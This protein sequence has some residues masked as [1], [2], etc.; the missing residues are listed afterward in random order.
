MKRETNVLIPD[1]EKAPALDVIRCLSSN[2]NINIHVLS[3]EK[4]VASRFSRHISSFTIIP[5][6]LE[7]QDLIEI[8][9]QN[10]RNKKI[11]VLLPVFI[12]KIKFISRYKESFQPL[13]NFVVP[14]LEDFITANNKWKLNNFLEE[15]NI[16]KPI[17]YD[18]DRLNEVKDN[19][20]FPVLLKPVY[21]VGGEGIIKVENIKELIA[22]SKYIDPND[23]Y[24]IQNYIHGYDIDMSVLCENGKILAFTIQKGILKRNVDSF[25]APIG[26]QF[27]YEDKIFN[28]IQKTMTALDWSGVAHIDLR[29]DSKENDFKI[30]EINPRYWGSLEGSEKVGV[31]FPYLHCLTSLGIEYPQP[32]YQHE[33]Y[34]KKSGQL[35]ILK[36]KITLQKDSYDF[37]KYTSFIANVIDPL[38]KILMTVLSIFKVI[39]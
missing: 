6:E 20:I 25:E 21:G 22:K 1:G 28:T 4:W 2:A 10:I 18:I 30:I 9:K 3:S 26:I 8:L 29:Y 32:D 38:P 37:T 19:L 33:S 34:V 39:K 24:V 7:D 36:S 27:L 13:T 23:K 16:K 35:K 14:N 15:N 17:T 12:Q 31:N 11:D 5:K